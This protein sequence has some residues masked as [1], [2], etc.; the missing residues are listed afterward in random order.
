MSCSHCMR[1]G[2]AKPKCPDRERPHE[3]LVQQWREEER[4]FIDDEL[5]V[6]KTLG[7]YAPE[8]RAH[9]AELAFR[10]AEYDYMRRVWQPLVERE[11][12][13]R[14]GLKAALS[15]THAEQQKP[16]VETAPPARRRRIDP[17]S[18]N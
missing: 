1:E 18:A 5:A 4:R 13:A 8:K 9:L 16:Q 14:A 15:R 17:G 12:I 6:A 10:R 11:G 2:H 3:E 7:K